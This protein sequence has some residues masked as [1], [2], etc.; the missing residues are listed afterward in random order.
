MPNNPYEPP[1][2]ADTT[3]ELTIEILME[4]LFSRRAANL[5]PKGLADVFDRLVWC[6]NDNGAEVL[7]VQKQWLE[8]DN[9]EKIRI[10]LAMDEVFPGESREDM[11][12]LLAKITSRWPELQDVC[13]AV[14]EQRDQQ[15]SS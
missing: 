4:F 8:G 5:P 11:H 3:Q 9:K 1:K 13:Q 7:Q 6:I 2:E 15:M 14:I 12:R 10:A